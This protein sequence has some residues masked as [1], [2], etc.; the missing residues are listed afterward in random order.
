MSTMPTAGNFER[1]SIWNK[2]P[3][4]KDKIR[5]ISECKPRRDL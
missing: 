2:P 1:S 3:K 5:G 4:G